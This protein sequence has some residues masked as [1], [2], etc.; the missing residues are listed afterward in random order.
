[1]KFNYTLVAAI[2]GVVVAKLIYEHK[3]KQKETED[4]DVVVEYF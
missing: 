1:M 3:K 4:L 2:L